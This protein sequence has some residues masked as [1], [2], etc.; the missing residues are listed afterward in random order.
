[1]ISM[2]SSNSAE[3]IVVLATVAEFDRW[4]AI[5]DPTNGSAVS[6]AP[7]KEPAILF[8][9][10]RVRLDFA[11]ISEELDESARNKQR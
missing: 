8:L 2:T 4:T 7:C 6:R 3:N 9:A 1:M 11:I 10:L 5:A